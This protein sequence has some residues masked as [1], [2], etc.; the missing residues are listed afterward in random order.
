MALDVSIF[1]TDT[2]NATILDAVRNASSTDYQ[3][4]IPAADKGG[5]QQTISALMDPGNRRWKNE[6]IDA[7]VNRIGVTI[8]RNNSWSNPL[9][10]F[11]RGMLEH[12]NTIEEIQ[13][14][15]LKAHNWNPDVDYTEA[16]L[17]GRERPEVQ[18]N[19]HTINRA[20]M[21]KV[22]VSEM[23]LNRAFL[24]DTGLAGFINQLME[25]PSTSDQWDEFLL[26]CSLLPEYEQNGGFYHVNVPNVRDMESDAD[27]ARLALR[28]L[29]AMAENLP[30]LSTKYNAARMP[31]SVKP[32]DLII[33]TTPEFNAAVDVEALAGAFHMDK[34]DFHG[35]KVII[36]QDNF[37]INS[38]QAILTTKDFFVVADALFE[39]TSQWNPAS[40]QN[41]YFLHHHEIISAS[42]FVPAVMF[43]TGNDDEVINVYVAPTT[44][45]VSALPDNTGNVPTSVAHGGLMALSAAIAP[46]NADTGVQW[47]LSGSSPLASDTFITQ[48]GVVHIGIGELNTT[49]TATANTT[50]NNP[51]NLDDANVVGTF[52]VTIS[53]A[54]ILVWPNSGVINNIFVD[55]VAV[56][57]FAAGTLTYS[58]NLPAH[59]EDGAS[60]V[61]EAENI[62]VASTGP[63]SAQITVAGPNATAPQ[64]VATIVTETKQG[65]TPVTYT[66]N[67]T[68][69]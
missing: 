6:F 15:L 21:Y 20:D 44:V 69:V 57:A 2:P 45:T 34:A 7:L 30:F 4:R 68:L 60:T 54:P 3:N 38:A 65:A 14:G 59:D 13:V 39:S 9:K 5:V 31:V 27:D 52:T 62:W 40:L 49:L 1:P 63:M 26:M 55:N 47:T 22:T 32:E 19:F 53:D 66:V 12:G 41:N 24:S 48:A 50:S 64:Y 17:F 37:G 28:K 35:R 23:M 58:M 46:A 43:W 67:I 56:P 25:A 18:A 11:K 51:D 8:A 10:E 16:M 42:R 29:R 36:P 61:I 33:L